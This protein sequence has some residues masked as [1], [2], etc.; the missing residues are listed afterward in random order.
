MSRKYCRK[1]R[2]RL[3]W[4]RRNCLFWAIS[5]FPTVFSKDLYCRHVKTRACLGNSWHFTTQSRLLTTLWKKP[6]ENMWEKEKMLVTSIF[7]YCHNVFFPSLN[8]FQFFKA[9]SDRQT[10]LLRRENGQNM[11]NLVIRWQNTSP[12]TLETLA[13]DLWAYKPHNDHTSNRHLCPFCPV[14][15]FEHTQN[16]TKRTS[17]DIAGQGAD[18]PDKKRT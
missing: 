3:L 8:K 4:A 17:P 10:D 13:I 1:R 7:S 6:F 11:Q 18:S 2:N 15:S 5:L 14:E 12:M 9:W 16:R